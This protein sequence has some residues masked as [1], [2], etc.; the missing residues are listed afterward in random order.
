M[1]IRLRSMLYMPTFLMIAFDVR[2][3]TNS[4][5]TATE[6]DDNTE[7]KPV[8][9]IVQ[10]QFVPNEDKPGRSTNQLSYLQKVVVKAIWKHRFAWPF[11]QP[12]DAVKLNLIVSSAGF[13][14]VT[15]FLE[16]P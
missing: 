9:G 14:V 13:A 12:V 5:M 4:T 10:P 2:L 7:L 15:E 3:Q 6:E 8:N 1:S 16:S 11:K